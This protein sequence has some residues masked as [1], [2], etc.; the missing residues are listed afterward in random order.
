M[1]ETKSNKQTKTCNIKNILDYDK[2]RIKNSIFF[3]VRSFV[4]TFSA[5]VSGVRQC[6]HIMRKTDFDIIIQNTYN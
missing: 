4:S 6:L 3:F 2:I 1:N 5:N